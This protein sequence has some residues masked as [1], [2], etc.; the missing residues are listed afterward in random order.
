MRLLYLATVAFVVSIGLI[1]AD[2]SKLLRSDFSAIG[3]HPTNYIIVLLARD[4]EMEMDEIS[5]LS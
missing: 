1:D 4:S 2:T 3:Y 5:A